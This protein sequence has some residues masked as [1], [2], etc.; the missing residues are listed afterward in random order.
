VSAGLAER[1]PAASG[2]RR[3]DLA[4]DVPGRPALQAGYAIAATVVVGVATGFSPWAGVA[5][6]AAAALG[7]AVLQWPAAAAIALVGLAPAISGLKRGLPV[8]GFRLS[9]LVIAGVATLVLVAADR[10]RRVRWRAFDWAALAY[11][12]ATAALGSLDLL[13]RGAGF[14]A[15]S[16]GTL[17]GPLQF[18]LLYRAVTVAL[19]DARD[20]SRALRALLVTSVPVAL[21]ALGQQ[22]DVGGLRGLMVRATGTDIYLTQLAA[23][24]APRATGPFPHWHQLAGYLLLVTLVAV[25]LLLSGSERAL[26]RRWLLA[27]LAVDGLALVQTA[28][29]SAVFGALGGALLVG[30]WLHRLRLVARGVLVACALAAILAGPVIVGRFEQQWVRPPGSTANP[31]VPNTIDFRWQVW[32]QQYFPVLDGRWLVGFGPDPP[33]GPRFAYSESLYISLLLRGGLLLLAVFGALMI[34]LW[35]LA[36]SGLHDPDPERRVVAAVVAATILVLVLIHVIEPYFLDS[37]PP[38]VLWALAGLLAAGAAGATRPTRPFS[39]R[40]AG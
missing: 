39:S 24:E 23:G 3:R 11:V 35:A 27:V 18:L 15:D 1:P 10:R 20:R 25:G 9:E 16:V 6:L 40:R 32:T 13:V 29:I 37:G 8:P 14:S 38:H 33:P 26:R 5:A 22:Y 31:F 19:P 4:R 34:A 7:A 17:A 2:P 28:T 21:L 30:F 36:R 12:V